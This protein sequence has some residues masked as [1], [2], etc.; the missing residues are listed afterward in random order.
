MHSPRKPQSS[1]HGNQD[2]DAV[3]LSGLTR[4][5]ITWAYWQIKNGKSQKQVAAQLEV[6]PRTLRRH[7]PSCSRER[8]ESVGESVVL[9][10]LTGSHRVHMAHVIEDLWEL[11]HHVVVR[12]RQ[13]TLQDLAKIRGSAD[14]PQGA[15]STR[16][17]FYRIKKALNAQGVSWD[18]NAL[19][20]EPSSE[21]VFDLVALSAF[22]KREIHL[23]GRVLEAFARKTGETSRFRG[24]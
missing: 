20:V 7:L 6:S 12:G 9:A 1:P 23:A 8:G 18:V 3:N 24:R 2:R 17:A 21:I 10:A 5:E 19:V 15:E 4:G 16:R 13:P 11:V 14:G 22:V